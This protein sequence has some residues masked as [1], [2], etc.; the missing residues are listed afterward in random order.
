MIFEADTKAGKRFDIILLWVILFS[1]LLVM[2]ESVKSVN[3]QIG[4]FL[5][6][7]EWIVT[8]I[9]TV[10]YL[11]RIYVLPKP[12]KYIFSFFGLVDLLSILPTFISFFLSGANGLMVIRALRLL[13]VFRIFK[14]SRYTKEAGLILYAL[15]ESQHKLFVFFVAI[16]AIVTILGAL[17]YLVEGEENGFKSIPES[18]Y[19]AIV[20]LTTVG[21][22]DIAPHTGLG[23]LISSFVMLLGYAIIAVP[24]GIVSVA[25][26]QNPK[27]ISTQVCP[28]CLSE[29][30]DADA[31]FCKRCG[32]RL[33]EEK[34]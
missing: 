24:T 10:E 29:D 20:T 18:I 27:T 21:Y 7:A 13:R 15:R 5:K 11:L 19:W 30:N 25:M 22:G 8:I 6:I 4:G 31:I 33:N 3:L 34:Q 9:F 2:L 32:N 1:I 16:L 14:L 17:M 26:R 12:W 28:N 23:K